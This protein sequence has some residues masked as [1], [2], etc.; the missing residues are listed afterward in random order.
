M[1]TSEVMVSVTGL[2]VAYSQ[3]PPSMKSMVMVGVDVCLHSDIN[4]RNNKPKANIVRLVA[5]CR[6]WK[7]A[8]CRHV[9]NWLA[10]NTVWELF[11]LH[12][13]RVLL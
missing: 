7:S 3:A 11:V 13:T 1:S 4:I 9:S 2:E 8:G 5:H 12:N 6:S 10:R